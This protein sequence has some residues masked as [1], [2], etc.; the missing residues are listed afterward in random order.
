MN[1]IYFEKNTVYAAKHIS[2]GMYLNAGQARWDAFWPTN[3][4]IF[5]D[6]CAYGNFQAYGG[7]IGNFQNN[8]LLTDNRFLFPSGRDIYTCLRSGLKRL[9]IHP[10]QSWNYLT[11]TTVTINKNLP[12]INTIDVQKDVYSQFNVIVTD[13]TNGSFTEK[14]LID[15]CPKKISPLPI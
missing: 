5:N 3:G 12:K 13:I 11:N 2:T 9:K 6:L 8:F 14:P 10:P 15:F 7:N 4:R 1:W